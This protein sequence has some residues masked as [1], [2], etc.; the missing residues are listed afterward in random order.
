MSN[1]PASM[2]ASELLV[3]FGRKTLSPVE[4]VRAALERIKRFN[5]QVNAYCLVD[6]EGA[7][8]AARESEQRWL[9]NKPLGILDGV[10]CSI[11]DIILTRGWP[12]LRGS[13]TVDQA[14]PWEEDAP[15]TARLREQG[16]IFLGKT[17]TPEFGWKGVTDSSLTGITRN[18]WN[19]QTTPG[20]SSGGASVAAALGMGALHIGTDGGGSIRIPAGFTGVFGHK[21]S[22]GRVPAYPLSP[23]GTVAHVGPITRSVVDAALMLTVLAQPDARDWHALP[24]ENKDYRINLD[25]GVLGWRIAF[26]LDLGYAE[27]EPE[28]AEKVA[29]AAQVFADLGAI[30]ERVDPGFSNP[31]DIFNKHWYTGAANALSGVSSE[32]LA[33]VEAGLREVAAQGASFSHMDYIAAVNARG[34]LGQI[35]SLFHEKYDLLLTPTLPMA[36]FAAG[37]ETPDPQQY[38]RWPEWT[39]FSYPFNLSQQ[40][41]ATIPCGFTRRGLP[42]GLQLVGPMHRDDRVLQAARAY[43]SVQPIVLPEAPR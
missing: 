36:A 38:K 11:K 16:A 34:R 9:H 27:V 30:V 22:F 39:P 17:T 37:Q 21:P 35:M 40:P 1:E 25:Q 24:F 41:A 23:F 15:V 32:R 4:A 3:Q 19:T 43:E 26:S 12:T 2:S 29:E 18:P 7:L 6:E 33:L 42:I 20:G 8:A 14:Q 5:D 28:I 31:L 10:P 13:K